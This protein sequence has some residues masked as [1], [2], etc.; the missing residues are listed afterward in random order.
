MQLLKTYCCNEPSP[1]NICNHHPH[2]VSQSIAVCL[3]APGGPS[4][5]SMVSNAT[6]L[7]QLLA[8]ALQ[9]LPFSLPPP[10]Q[11]RLPPLLR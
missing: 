9:A 4:V 11:L 1:Y 8:L 6:H 3:K 2:S 7:F 5:S 10:P